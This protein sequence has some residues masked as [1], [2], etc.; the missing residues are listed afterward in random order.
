MRSI[1]NGYQ[2]KVITVGLEN[3]V[4]TAMFQVSG[5]GA[6]TT[7]TGYLRD[8]ISP[9]VS[10]W[11]GIRTFEPFNRLSAPGVA[12]VAIDLG[13][14]PYEVENP[15][16]GRPP[17]KPGWSPLGMNLRTNGG[18]RDN[19]LVQAE[20]VPWPPGGLVA[21]VSF[22]WSTTKGIGNEVSAF[23]AWTINATPTY[24]REGM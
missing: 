11:G 8:A 20:L 19:V 1:L 17:V 16:P 6:P 15:N 9:M 5:V 18:P 4:Q 24:V 7:K 2:Q 23:I 3:V 13:I 10:I 21:R 14:L 22:K 12:L